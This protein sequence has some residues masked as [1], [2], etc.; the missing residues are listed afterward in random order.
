M[1]KQEV[2][3]AIKCGRYR[4]AMEMLGEAMEDAPISGPAQMRDLLMPWAGKKQESFIVITLDGAHKPIRVIEVSKGL[5]NRTIVHPREV[6]VEAI[7]DRAAAII[8][9]HN[10]PS[11]LV[12][13]SA[14][15]R[16]ITHRLKEAGDIIGIPLL[17]HVIVGR[18]RGQARWYS[19]VENGIYK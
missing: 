2:Y 16:D 15:D 12:E 3:D 18:Y 4:D 19:F 5:L 8:V 17:D 11:G 10:H 14:E 7:T 13:P 6:F 1:R 9:G